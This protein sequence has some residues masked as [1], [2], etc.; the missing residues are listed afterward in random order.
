M[1]FRILTWSVIPYAGM[2]IF[3]F[4]LL[5]D[6]KSKLDPVLLNHEKIHLQQQKELWIVPF[7][8]IYFFHYLINLLRFFN[9]HKAYRNIIFEREAYAMEKDHAYLLTRERFA[10]MKF[11]N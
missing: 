1:R 2:A 3:P 8:L 11:R 5:K 10:F 7:Y 4:I 6:K 9:H